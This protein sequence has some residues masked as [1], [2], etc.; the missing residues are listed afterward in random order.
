MGDVAGA[1]ACIRMLAEDHALRRTLSF[2]A[3]ARVSAHH[4][5]DG[6]L[7]GIERAYMQSIGA[8]TTRWKGG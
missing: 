5:F 4:S 1:A 3:R 7:D 2:S 8:G 6:F